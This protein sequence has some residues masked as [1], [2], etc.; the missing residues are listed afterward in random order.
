MSNPWERLLGEASRC[1]YCG[2]CEPSCPTLGH[3][4]HRGYGPRGRVTLIR[5]LAEGRLEPTPAVYESLYSCLLCRRC[6]ASCPTGIRV[7]WLVREA[8]SIL[9]SLALRG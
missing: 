2:F 1:L 8:R 7:A 4:G 9:S 5:L 6:E 3:G